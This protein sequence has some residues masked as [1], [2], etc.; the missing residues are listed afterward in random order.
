M[1][2]PVATEVSVMGPR[3]L[4][5]GKNLQPF[6]DNCDVSIWVKILEWDKNKNQ[7]KLTNKQAIFLFLQV[8]CIQ[9]G[10]NVRVQI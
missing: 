2:I 7:K 4:S 3:M 9:D 6:A 8:L 1:S 5:K 10:E